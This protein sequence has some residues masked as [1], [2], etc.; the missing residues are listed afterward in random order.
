[1]IDWSRVDQLRAEV[2]ADAFDEVVE[3]FLD[4]V[5]EVV[6]RLKSGDRTAL[7]DDLHFL[8]GSALT[9]GFREL[10]GLCVLEEMSVAENGP[11]AVDLTAL[12]D[13]YARSRSVF[14]EQLP[15]RTQAA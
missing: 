2:G 15:A 7:T 11:D 10:S 6:R 12:T 4:E 14:L 1:M 13:C 3:P 9:L 5:D 8:K